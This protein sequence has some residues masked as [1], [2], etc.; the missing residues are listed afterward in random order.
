MYSSERTI[1]AS[2]R[3]ANLTPG[4]LPIWK[5]TVSP[6]N[7]QQRSSEA[8]AGNVKSDFSMIYPQNH[9]RRW[10]IPY[11][12]PFKA[13]ENTTPWDRTNITPISSSGSYA[14]HLSISGTSITIMFNSLYRKFLFMFFFQK[15]TGSRPQRVRII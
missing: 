6:W 4:R 8:T 9:M 2:I 12:A 7:N 5:A 11:E 15:Q 1:G 13:I 10:S 14:S 3:G